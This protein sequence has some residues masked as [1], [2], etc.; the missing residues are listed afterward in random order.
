MASRSPELTVSSQERNAVS[1]NL[2]PAMLTR[3][4][5]QWSD[6]IIPILRHTRDAPGA[7]P[8]EHRPLLVEITLAHDPPELRCGRIDPGTEIRR[9]HLV[10]RNGLHLQPPR[11]VVQH[12]NLRQGKKKPR[13][14]AS[15]PLHFP[16]H[17]ERTKARMRGVNFEP[18]PA[19]G[20]AA[21]SRGRR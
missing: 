11:P 5:Y 20:R 8:E 9:G 18:S 17:R 14:E 2:L 21:M 19:S 16:R 3:P 12:L 4:G 6:H 13:R 15:S 1:N 7:R 10:P